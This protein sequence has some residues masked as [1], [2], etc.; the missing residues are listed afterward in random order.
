M[1]SERII[2]SDGSSPIVKVSMDKIE[3]LKRQ[4]ASTEVSDSVSDSVTSYARWEDGFIFLTDSGLA[5]TTSHTVTLYYWKTSDE[6][7]SNTIDPQVNT[8][9]DTALW[10]GAVSDLTNNQAWEVKFERE[11]SRQKSRERTMHGEVL[12]VTSAGDYD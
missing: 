2:V 12:A 3:Y 10:Y 7:I 9:W 6:T 5:P 1:L 8:R 4:A 11:F